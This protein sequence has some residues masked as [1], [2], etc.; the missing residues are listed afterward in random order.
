M[1]FGWWGLLVL[2]RFTLLGSLVLVELTPQR[3]L[4]LIELVPIELTLK[5]H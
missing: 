2:V 3:P 5:A 4:V 1:V